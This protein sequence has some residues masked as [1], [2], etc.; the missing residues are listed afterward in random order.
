MTPANSRLHGQITRLKV[1]SFIKSWMTRFGECPAAALV[2]EELNISL[3]S[4]TLHMRALQNATGLPFPIPSSAARQGAYGTPKSSQA[5]LARG[6]QIDENTL[7]LL[8]LFHP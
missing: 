4:S 5:R 1:F 2:A 8:S 3:S 6:L 7:D